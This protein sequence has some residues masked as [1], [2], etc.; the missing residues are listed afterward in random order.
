MKRSTELAIFAAAIY[1]LIPQKAFAYID[2]GT[3]S[4]VIQ[5]ITAAFI[6]FLFSIKMFWNNIKVYFS[7]LLN[8][9]QSDENEISDEK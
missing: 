1:F 8:K 5:V 9:Q 3:G 6:G 2:P 7:K 4:Y